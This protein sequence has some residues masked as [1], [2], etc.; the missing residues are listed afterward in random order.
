MAIQQELK[1]DAEHMALIHTLLTERGLERYGL[2]AFSSEGTFTPDGYEETSGYALSSNDRA[3]FFWT[4]W[5]EAAQRTTFTLWQ[6]TEP[7]I[8][9]QDDEEYQAARVAAGLA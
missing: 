8:E 2:F 5:D 9:W 4:G 3:Y 7:Q 1:S 6:P